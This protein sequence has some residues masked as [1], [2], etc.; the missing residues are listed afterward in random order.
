MGN[1]CGGMCSDG[2]QV[3]D[4]ELKNYDS[5]KP[6]NQLDDKN[7]SDRY[8]QPIDESLLLAYTSGDKQKLVKIQSHYRGQ[9]T[10]KRL[11]D[12]NEFIR[13]QLEQQQTG[14][15]VNVHN[16]KIDDSQSESAIYSG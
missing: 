3:M 12:G 14:N 13:M 7:L 8:A 16:F 5:S 9:D 4:N 11:D 10:K 2:G 6:F 1:A 15:L